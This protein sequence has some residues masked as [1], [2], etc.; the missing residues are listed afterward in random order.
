MPTDAPTTDLLTHLPLS[1]P[2]RWTLLGA[3]AF[4]AIYWFIRCR[5]DPAMLPVYIGALGGAF[6]GAKL[7]YLFAEGWR[8]WPLEDRWL[9]LATGKSVLG[10]LLGGY[11]GVEGMKSLIGYRKSTGDAF[12]LV[13]PLGIALGRVGCWLQGCC[14]GRPTTLKLLAARDALGVTRWPSAQIELVFQLL[15]FAFMMILRK[16][17]AFTNR[18]IF[19]YFMLYGTFRFAHEWLRDTP[20]LA[21]GLSGYQW[22]SLLLIALGAMMFRRRGKSLTTAL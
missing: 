19:L 13:V 3:I 11:L 12:A 20:H 16:N 4:S 1:G 15:A 17:P 18:L 2:Y 21:L 5:R 14:L 10:G 7:V 8:D 9:R 6:L 22:I